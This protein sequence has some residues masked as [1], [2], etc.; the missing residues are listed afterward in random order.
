M[1]TLPRHQAVCCSAFGTANIPD[2]HTS[3]CLSVSGCCI[4]LRQA[5]G[6]AGDALYLTFFKVC[7]QLGVVSELMCIAYQAV[8]NSLLHLNALCLDLKT[9]V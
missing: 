2:H 5:R 7:L 1:K 9:S 4:Y 3:L 8:V 6:R